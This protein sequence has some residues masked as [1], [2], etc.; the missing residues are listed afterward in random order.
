MSEVRE[1]QSDERLQMPSDP[2]SVP[3][4][5]IDVAQP[6]LFANGD[7]WKYFERLRSEAPVHYCEDGFEGP[8]W[9]VTK[10]DDI[11]HVDSLSESD[12]GTSH[13]AVPGTSFLGTRYRVAAVSSSAGVA[14]KWR[15][16]SS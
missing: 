9:S 4:D 15:R 5:K 3:L 13:Q 16:S 7:H 6:H 1:P 14:W 11:C 10:Y 12:I 2:Y 8:Y